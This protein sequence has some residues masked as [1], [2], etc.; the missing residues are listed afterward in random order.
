MISRIVLTSTV[1]IG[2]YIAGSIIQKNRVLQELD[3]SDDPYVIVSR[4]KL[5]EKV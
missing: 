3:S 5:K 4:Q 2:G 1:G